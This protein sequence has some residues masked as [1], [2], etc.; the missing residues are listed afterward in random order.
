M[1]YHISENPNIE[2]FIPRKTESFMD[3][4]L[5]VWAIDEEHLVNYYFPRDCPRII[6]RYTDNVI[7]EDKVKF[8][9]NT[10]SKT[11]ITVENRGYNAIKN[12]L[13]YKYIFDKKNFRLID[14]IAGYYICEEKIIPKSIEK[15]ENIIDELLKKEIELKFTPNIFPLRNSLIKS[16][17]YDY[18]IIRFRNAKE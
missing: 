10:V 6:Y 17:L 1:V 18:S 2:E 7:E 9:P 11:I 15:I 14:E 13:L 16:S 12:A 5:V 8:F 4:P 3:L